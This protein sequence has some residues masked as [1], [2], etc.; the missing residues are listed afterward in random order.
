[1]LCC[2]P[3]RER[4]GLG[5]DDVTKLL[6]GIRELDR[7]KKHVPHAY[8]PFFQS[9]FTVFA[10]DEIFDQ[11]RLEDMFPNSGRP[12]RIDDA[13]AAGAKHAALMPTKDERRV[14]F[15][16]ISGYLTSEQQSAFKSQLD[17]EWRRLRNK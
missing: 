1:M 16:F 7:L 4:A 8:L 2:N 11:V 14:F 13:I 3:W 12:S 6:C 17:A 15:T 10:P 5:C 9:L